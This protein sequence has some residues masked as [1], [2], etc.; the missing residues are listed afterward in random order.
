[1]GAASAL[2]VVLGVLLILLMLEDAFETIVLPR[3]VR[4]PISLGRYFLFLSWLPGKTLARLIKHPGRRESFLSYFG[5]SELIALLILWVIGCVVGYALIYLGLVPGRGFGYYLFFSGSTFTTVGFATLPASTGW[6]HA[7]SVA[8][9]AT[10]LA[11]VAL[12]V[13]Y[14]P[15][16]QQSFS[17]REAQLVMLDEWAG[18]PPSAEALLLRLETSSELTAVTFFEQWERWAAE[19][20]ESHLSYPV[21]AYFR[22]QHDDHSWVAGLATILDTTA[23]AVAAGAPEVVAWPA[24]RAFAIARHAS[25]D[26][27]QI[28]GAEPRPPRDGHWTDVPEE[29]ARRAAEP[30][31]SVSAIDFAERMRQ[32]RELYEPYIAA[33]SEHLLMVLPPFTP[34]AG[35]LPA[36]QRTAWER[37]PGLQLRH[38]HR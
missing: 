6:T 23:V 5:P 15:S 7:V 24:Y 18:S 21:L 19:V 28:L 3:R 35:A 4:R 11:F 34:P 33:L 10:G 17:R 26:I 13:A 2:S 37:A 14:L 8:E 29:Q 22:S 1:M 9:S 31:M 16:L 32:E 30:W 36:W 25:V 38:R 20:L 12:I 27:C